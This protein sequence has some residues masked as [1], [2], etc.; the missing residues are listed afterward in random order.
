MTAC[1]TC[2]SPVPDGGRFCPTCGRPVGGPTTDAQRRV[3]TVVFADLADF[4]ALSEGRD[5]ESVKELLDACFGALVPVITAHGGH[6]DKIIG[7]ELMA[8]FGAPVVHE[9]D[10]ER[11]VRASLALLSALRAIDPALALRVGVNTGEVLAGPVGPAHGY[12]VTGDAVNTAHR[13]AASADPGEIL[14][15]ERTHGATVDVVRYAE[16]G[17]FTLRGKHEPVRAWSAL[18]VTSSPA[19]RWISGLS[20]PLIGRTAELADLSAIV[21]RSFVTARSTVVVVTGEPGVGKTRLA[22]ELSGAP[23]MARHG[24]RVLW[25]GCPPYGAAGALSPLADLVRAALLVDPTQPRSEQVRRVEAQL[26]VLTPHGDGGSVGLTARIAQLLG[27]Y[28]LP[29]RPSDSEAGP[30]RARVVD[31]LLSAV[32]AL[33]AALASERPLFIVIDDLQWASDPVI[34]FL[35]QL[36]NRLGPAPVSVLA[37][38]RDDLL[39][40]SPAFAV[41]GVGLAAVNLEPLDRRSAVELIGAL[42]AG[43]MPDGGGDGEPGRAEDP[44][45][46]GP[47]AEQRILDAAGGNPLLLEQLVHYLIETGSV[48]L[49]GGRWSAAPLD[50]TGLPD[51][52][53]SLIGARLD[54]L[55]P[56]E[57]AVL[58]HASVV[59]RRFWRDALAHVTGTGGS[60]EVDAII[61]RLVDRNLIDRVAPDDGFGELAFRHVL[62]RDVAYAALPIGERA[63]RHARLASWLRQRFA[64][65]DSGP[66]VGLLAHHYERAVTLSREIDHTDPGLT[67]AA[68]TAL[69]RA[70]RDAVRHEMLR[71]ANRW[72][73]RAR[74][75]GSFD[76]GANLEV[77][78]EHGKV[79]LAM[80]RLDVARQ[81]FLDVQRGAAILRADL[82][83]SATAYLGTIARLNGDTDAAREHFEQAHRRWQALHDE[84][85][86]LDTLRLE[87]W[88]ELTAGRPRAALP[89]LLRALALEER[90]GDDR[91]GGDL[92]KNLGWCELLAGE[93][94]AARTHL[95]EAADRLTVSGEYGEVGWCFGIL[96]FTLLHTGQAA[97]GLGV[98]R[99]LRTTTRAQGDPWSEWT[100]AILEAACLLSLGDADEAA[101]LA[102]EA[103]RTFDELGD[104]YG[105]VMSQL[106]RGMAARALGDLAQARGAL[107]VGLGMAEQVTYV[108]EQA[109]VLAELAA[110]EAEDGRRDE[111]T[112]RARAA[113]ALVRAG[114]GDHESGMRALTTLASLERAAGDLSSA[115]MLLEEAIEGVSVED[116]TDAWRQA[117]AALVE[118]LV[119]RGAIGRAEVLLDDAEQPPSDGVRTRVM[120]ARARR[121]LLVAGGRRVDGEAVLAAVAASVGGR[122]LSFLPGGTLDREAVRRSGASARDQARA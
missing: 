4:T 22:L 15:G 82:A 108:G 8:V 102:A 63:E 78:L 39:E 114:I 18:S 98:A 36:P 69:V 86:E 72:F 50:A 85:G 29:S 87:G 88:S 48:R 65:A 105:I 112:R 6:V 113:L 67:G 101:S 74:D 37:L 68:F 96:G 77:G 121:A 40:R 55:P 80:R 46:L 5:P 1:A 71:D 89:R 110:V 25:A 115:E 35:R 73:S 21:E 57:R 79:Q 51:G 117:A 17:P 10:P 58:Q 61:D 109:R 30:T 99:S 41:G 2:G 81:S 11:A 56:E 111:A 3:V 43:A 42:L 91:I 64:D 7:D 84:R 90:L 53:R 116:R 119:E 83:A 24:A 33:L 44:P 120:L 34:T 60:S 95:W 52:V 94:T 47:V 93:I 92:L 31:Q 9:D 75:L 76:V 100:C 104:S 122:P 26:E 97:V 118:L 38:A 32:R 54:A 66:A 28:D 20:R 59:G 19:H 14:V 27:L 107:L 45:R 16:R 12:T 23:V 70:A 13:L 49:D 103:H 62:T 106:V